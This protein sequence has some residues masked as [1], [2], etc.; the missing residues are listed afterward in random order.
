TTTTTSTTTTAAT[1]TGA[2][3][4][5]TTA[6]GGASTQVPDVTG[7]GEIAAAGQVEAAGLVPDTEPVGASG[8]PGSVS[9]QRPPG[10]D[11]ANAGSTVTLD[12]VTGSN[13]PT[14]QIPN[15]VGRSAADARAALAAARVTFKTA[16]K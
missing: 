13:R 1:T 2:T 3:A 10:G 5:A 7:Q 16:Y 14:V 9:Q 15:V 12:I 4:S 6:A 11:Q 8:A